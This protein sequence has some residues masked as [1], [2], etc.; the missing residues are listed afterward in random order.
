MFLVIKV[1]SY[2]FGAIERNSLQPSGGTHYFVQSYLFLVLV[3]CAFETTKNHFPS[4]KQKICLYLSWEAMCSTV[5]AI[6]LLGTT[7]LM[8]VRMFIYLYFYLKYEIN[9]G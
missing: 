7:N 2:S 1:I 3:V 6:P 9:L 5:Y 4:Q 8:N